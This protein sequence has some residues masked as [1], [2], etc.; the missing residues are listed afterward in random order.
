MLIF[1][2]KYVT[3]LYD[4]DLPLCSNETPVSLRAVFTGRWSATPSFSKV[5]WVIAIGVKWAGV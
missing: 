3:L 2:L 1:L 4:V 5:K